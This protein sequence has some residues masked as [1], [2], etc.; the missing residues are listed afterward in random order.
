MNLIAV[1][2]PTLAK[3]DID[4][5]WFAG[6][7]D[8]GPLPETLGPLIQHAAE[9]L[10]TSRLILFGPSGGGYAAIVFGTMF[11]DSVVLAVNP[12]L[13]LNARPKARLEKYLEVAHGDRTTGDVSVL[14]KEF[15]LTRVQDQLE[16]PLDFNLLIFQNSGDTVYLNNQ[17]TPFLS[18]FHS[19]PRVHVRL[20]NYATGH[21]PI[22]GEMLRDI[23]R[24]LKQKNLSDAISQ[25]GFVPTAGNPVFEGE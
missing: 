8:T 15:G 1:S 21:K 14:L 9:S 6:D 12:R 13:D 10:G 4:L 18:D 17:L 19:D 5:G 2:D 7:K 25:A 24:T 22:P 16:K 20:E 3:G 23:L 11:P